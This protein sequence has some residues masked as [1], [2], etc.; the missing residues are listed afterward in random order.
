MV[1][2]QLLTS[3]VRQCQ[4]LMVMITILDGEY[5]SKDDHL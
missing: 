3:I 5:Q 2:I 1:T 4:I